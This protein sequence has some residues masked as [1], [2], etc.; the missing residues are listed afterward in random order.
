[1]V[2]RATLVPVDYEALALAHRGLLAS[3]P[4]EYAVRNPFSLSIMLSLA[5]V[6]YSANIFS[7]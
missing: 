6:F 7:I 3:D 1:V 4:V 2:A 5:A